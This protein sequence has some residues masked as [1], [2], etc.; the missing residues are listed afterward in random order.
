[1]SSICGT[2]SR[3]QMFQV[4][5][6][7]VSGSSVMSTSR[8]SKWENSTV[9]ALLL[10]L[11][12]LRLLEVSWSGSLLFSLVVVILS[13]FG[14]LLTSALLKKDLGFGVSVIIASSVFVFV[15]Q[16]LLSSGLSRHLS[17]WL[18]LGAMT[19]FVL[20]AKFRKGTSSR[21]RD[22]VS[23]PELQFIL[24]IGL[25][26]LSLSHSWLIPFALAS[27]GWLSML[28]RPE[29]RMVWRFTAALVVCAGWI[30]S[31]VLRPDRWWYFYQG[32]LSQFYE[33]ISWS[34]AWWG[35]VEHPGQVGSSLTNYHWF[36]YAFF[37]ALSSTA[38]LAP[39]DALMKVG[40]VL[41]PTLFASLFLLG[42]RQL[43][44]L[45][46]LNWIALVLAT[47]AME[48]SRTDSLVFSMITAFTLIAVVREGIGK[49]FHFG[50][51]LILALLSPM[52]V[53]AKVSTAAV[54]GAIFGIVVVVQIARRERVAWQPL[55]ILCGSLLIV[56]LIFMQDN[57]PEMLTRFK[58][59]P[60]WSLN[61]LSDLLEARSV[62][63]AI[64][65]I[66]GLFLIASHKQ[67]KQTTSLDF[68]IVVVST[69]APILYV[70]LAG[71][72]SRYFGLPGVW[73][74]TMLVM[75]K[76]NESS[77]SESTK[78]VKNPSVS[79]G[80]LVMAFA[81]I[82]FYAP[83]VLRRIDSWMVFD[84]E[85]RPFLSALLTSSGL[86]LGILVISPLIL[87][88]RAR[89]TAVVLLLSITLGVFTG[90]SAE[91]FS[92]LRFW[93]AG[94]YE[95]SNPVQ[96]TF[97]KSDLAELAEFVRANTS[98]TAVLASNQFCCFGEGWQISGHSDREFRHISVIDRLTDTRWGG[99][100]YLLPAYT[101][102]RFL[103]QGLRFQLYTGTQSLIGEPLEKLRLSLEFANRPSRASLEGLKLFGVTG[104]VVNLT[105]TDEH[106]WS[107]F[108]EEAF[109][110]GEFVYLEFK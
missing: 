46:S 40:V 86:V 60:I 38:D 106:D 29:P 80:V 14:R 107:D 41:I 75:W 67:I 78:E 57:E 89:R 92:K 31:L 3:A 12:T 37:G 94:I 56:Y 53:L 81:V 64:L 21:E 33:A 55:A 70:V 19:I 98:E 36:S 100:N 68:S 82:G 2:E 99:A 23:A 11:A 7:L 44:P 50:N 97:G 45:F 73:F 39:W 87:R 101:R 15:G 43:P 52:L 103:V 85:W 1:M 84:R 30:G 20:V 58:L 6:S 16:L 95:S 4:P 109:R 51:A 66:G 108:A 26:A 8:S 65:W 49:R 42:S 9:G 47:T 10:V 104:F 110:V 32:R 88:I 17:H 71:P 91:Y 27:A 69:L 13:V 102:R 77:H 35:V 24:S 48:I 74:I 61:E 62:L 22:V 54:V 93:G 90:Q 25:T 79:I 34:T 5:S 28:Q 105:L 83:K 96:A 18:P 63:N 72:H 59:D 76:L